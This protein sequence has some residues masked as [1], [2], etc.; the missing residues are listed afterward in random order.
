MVP[1][2]KNQRDPKWRYAFV[3]LLIYTSAIFSHWSIRYKPG[4]EVLPKEIRASLCTALM[5]LFPEHDWE[6]WRFPKIPG[7]LWQNT[8]NQIRFLKYVEQQLSLF[9]PAGWY[10]VKPRAIANCG[11]AI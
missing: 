7:S 5:T 3:A 1:H 9:G 6:F 8:E 2:P 10:A 11:G 4:K